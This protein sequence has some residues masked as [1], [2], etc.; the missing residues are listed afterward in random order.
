MVA[1]MEAFSEGNIGEESRYVRE[2]VLGAMGVKK[3][4][5]AHVKHDTLA[6]F[7]AGYSG[8]KRMP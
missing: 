5:R 1:S 4:L 7:K 8:I 2:G 3:E 6:N